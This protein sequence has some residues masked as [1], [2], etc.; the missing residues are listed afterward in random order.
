MKTQSSLI[1]LQ[2]HQNCWRRS[3]KQ[4]QSQKQ[5]QSQK[6]RQS[7]KMLQSQRRLKIQKML[8]IPRSYLIQIQ[9]TEKMK[10]LKIQM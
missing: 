9:M 8:M 1:Y 3:Q 7:Q 10:N 2:L 5:R 4:L 6:P